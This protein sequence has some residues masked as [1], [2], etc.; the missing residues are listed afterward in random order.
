MEENTRNMLAGKPYT[1]AT[2]EI[3]RISRQSHRLCHDFNQ[4]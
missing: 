1:P 3:H 4:L 2:D